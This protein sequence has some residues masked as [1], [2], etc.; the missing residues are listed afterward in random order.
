L[1]ALTALKTILQTSGVEAIFCTAVYAG[2]GVICL[3]TPDLVWKGIDI[4]ISA[5]VR[6]RDIGY[7][8]PEYMIS[9]GLKFA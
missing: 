9:I 3:L 1:I 5:T 2:C 7:I 6:S 8:I 4:D